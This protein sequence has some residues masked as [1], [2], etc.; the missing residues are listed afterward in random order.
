MFKNMQKIL[1]KLSER[2]NLSAEEAEEAFD[3]C[4]TKDREGYFFTALTMG[5]MAKGITS[6]EL[7][8]FCKSRQ[9]FLPEI[10]L[11][12]E[13]SQITDNSG[14][15]GDKLKTF[16]VST[17]AA[18][19]ISAAG[20]PMAKQAFFSITGAG[21]SADLFRAFGIDVVKL[22]NPETIKRTLE[23]VGFCPYIADFLPKPEQIPGIQNF[24]RKRDEIG[25]K[26]ITPYHL[27]AN[28]LTPIKMER[29][30]YGVF[31]NRYL[32]VLAKLFQKLS[33]KRVLLIHGV[34]GL[35]EVSNIG[36]TE[37][38]ELKENKINRYI[39]SPEDFG[40]KK[41]TYDDIKAVNFE[42]N[43]IDFLRILFN[44]ERGAKRD[45]VLMNSAASLYVMNK[46]SSFKDGVELAKQIL[47]ENKAANKL[48][49]LVKSTGDI[50]KLNQ[51]KKKANII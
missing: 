24:V 3:I 41:A 2:N 30:I 17:T 40:I 19:I 13:S 45:I 1:T 37:I 6:D 7:F 49:E 36:D 39:V 5:L 44:K 42:Q 48:V 51:W 27:A 18:F 50:E 33:Y 31:D 28:V 22:S 15:G 23:T 32:N 47:E 12:I 9:K 16:N 11:G 29:R 46:T 20:I 14:T 21:G 26:Y 34:D 8:G 35:D 43:I 10:K 4:I 38:V 25:L